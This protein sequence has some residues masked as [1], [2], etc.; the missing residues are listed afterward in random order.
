[1]ETL[2]Q[3]LTMLSILANAVV[4]GTDVFCAIVQR[5]ALAHV[6]D[7]ALTQSMG[8][9]HRFGDRRMPVPGVTG[10]VTALAVAATAGIDGDATVSVAA[11]VASLALIVW[12]VVYG[13]VSAPVN[14]KLTAAA[15]AGRTAPDARSLQRTWDGVINARVLLQ[16]LALGAL[17]VALAA[18]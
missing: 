1:M 13:T 7:S 10:L 9:V 5:P 3:A 17:C 2:I 6:D 11:G 14:K 15:Q 12:L 4:Y 18:S 8:Q 16:T